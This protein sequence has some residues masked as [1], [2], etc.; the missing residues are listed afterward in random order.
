MRWSDLVGASLTSLR[1][2]FFRTLLTVLGVVIGTTSVIVMV[3]LGVGM[4]TMMLNSMDTNL[5]LRQVTVYGPPTAESSPDSGLPTAM[6]E[7]MLATLEAMP[8]VERTW[9]I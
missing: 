7:T 6:D 8:G 9:P 5:A 2:R 4:S 3:S 1:Q